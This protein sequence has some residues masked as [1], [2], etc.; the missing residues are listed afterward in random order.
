MSMT[1]TTIRNIPT[2]VW[3]LWVVLI[4]VPAAPVNAMVSVYPLDADDSPDSVLSTRIITDD[5]EPI[6]SAWQTFGGLPGGDT[7]LNPDGHVNG[8]GEPAVLVH[9]GTGLTIAVWAKNRPGGYDIVLSRFSAGSWSTPEVLV[10]STA[11]ELDPYLLVDPADG[12]VHLLYWVRDAGPRVMH[13]QAPADLSGWS[14][15]AQVSGLGE[16]A[17]RPAAVFVAGTLKVVYE[18]H[19][20]GYGS[21]PRQIALA[22][23]VGS[24]FTTESVDATSEA[25][26]NWPQVHARAGRLWIDWV[27]GPDAMAWTVWGPGGWEALRFEGFTGTEDRTFRVRGRIELQALE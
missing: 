6:G 19:D 15:A 24:G 17:V 21:T 10:G 25:A 12:S 16:I 8:D 2:G 22:T 5:G 9:P 20:L 27:H 3:L 4:L 23:S 11:D 13:K 1:T 18:R 7:L 26:P 14:P